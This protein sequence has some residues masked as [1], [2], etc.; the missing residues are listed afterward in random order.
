MTSL[1]PL[2]LRK[3][4]APKWSTSPTSPMIVRETP[5]LTK[6]SPPA[7]LTSDNRVDIC[8]GHLGRHHDH[9]LVLLAPWVNDEKAPGHP[10]GGLES[11]RVPRQRIIERAASPWPGE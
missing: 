4:S 7:V 1:T 9:H 11:C 8:P 2:L 3:L 5:L 10:A 6:A